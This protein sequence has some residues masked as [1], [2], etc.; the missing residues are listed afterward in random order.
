M[1][2]ILLNTYEEGFYFTN[3]ENAYKHLNGVH[4][5]TLIYPPL[6]YV[7]KDD[8]YYSNDENIEYACKLNFN[9]IDNVRVI[10]QKNI[11][12]KSIIFEYSIRAMNVKIFDYIIQFDVQL[13]KNMIK[14]IFYCNQKYMLEK[15]HEKFNV[16]NYI[17]YDI[18]MFSFYTENNEDSFYEYFFNLLDFENFKLLFKGVLKDSLL[19]KDLEYFITFLINTNKTDII[20]YIHEQ[21]FTGDDEHNVQFLI[22][23]TL[24]FNFTQKHINNL[25]CKFDYEKII[26][27][28]NK[29]DVECNI[30]GF[31]NAFEHFNLDL[32]TFLISDRG[33]ALP[34]YDEILFEKII[35]HEKVIQILNWFIKNKYPIYFNDVIIDTIENL[36][37]FE[38]Y[39]WYENNKNNVRVV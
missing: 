19:N 13:T 11:N 28:E 9:F 27:Y 38:I 2:F 20:D 18:L 8:I 31:Y 37:T 23:N 10:I 3:F 15:I 5:I 4:I 29:Y 36:K 26:Y 16:F 35:S 14:D 32:I 33:F 30:K 22:Q 21:Y 7:E 12:I 39:E 17:S 24:N 1:S 6:N 34:L 25:C